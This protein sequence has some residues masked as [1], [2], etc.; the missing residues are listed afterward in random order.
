MGDWEE[1][2]LVPIP[3]RSRSRVHFLFP[4]FHL[5][6]AHGLSTS[7][8]R[9]RLFFNLNKSRTLVLIFILNYFDI[10]TEN[11]S[12]YAWGYSKAC[13]TKEDQ[14][15][16]KCVMQ[17]ELN[18]VN[19]TS[20]AGG[21]SHSVAL[22]NKVIF[23]WGSNFEVRHLI[24]ITIISLATINHQ[25]QHHQKLTALSPPSVAQEHH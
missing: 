20:L 23:S 1:M 21:D 14:L 6:K 2:N 24:R 15:S 16:P 5:M 18:T 3:F 25:H 17:N 10:C 4:V 13:G 12:L 22:I 9:K 8:Q 11:G 19:V 7:R